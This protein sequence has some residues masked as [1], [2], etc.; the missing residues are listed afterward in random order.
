MLFRIADRMPG[1]ID[2]KTGSRLWQLMQME[3]IRL[4]EMEANK[5]IDQN[6]QLQWLSISVLIAGVIKSLYLLTAADWWDLSRFM[7][8]TVVHE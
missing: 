1:L 4:I 3:A 2:F 7:K 8:T 5:E 6:L